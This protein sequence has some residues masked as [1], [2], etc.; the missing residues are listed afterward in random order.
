MY[1]CWETRLQALGGD[2]GTKPLVLLYAHGPGWV[3]VWMNE[4]PRRTRCGYGRV[5]N[6]HEFQT[7]R[8]N[9]ERSEV[10]VPRVHGQF[11]T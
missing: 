9:R 11:D 4:S 6:Q 3:A 2:E 7:R 5:V 10:T 1:R 8:N